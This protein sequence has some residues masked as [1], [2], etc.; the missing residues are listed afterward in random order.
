MTSE[1][2][3]ASLVQAGLKA[4]PP[5]MLILKVFHESH[6]RHLTADD[7]LRRLVLQQ[8][9]AS[10]ATVYRALMQFA[11]AGLLER[12]HFDNGAA[13]FEL[14]HSERHGHLVC[15]GCGKVAEFIDPAIEQHQRVVAAAHGFL[16][17]HQAPL[18]YGLCA[19]CAVSQAV[20]PVAQDAAEQRDQ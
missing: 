8:E 2:M 10:V 15:K 1:E 7:V 12:S 17:Y 5:R 18:L 19:N 16:L 14:G 6:E 20:F 9:N 11:D 4:T 3:A 13:I